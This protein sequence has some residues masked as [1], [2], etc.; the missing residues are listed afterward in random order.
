MTSW[1]KNGRFGRHKGFLLLFAAVAIFTILQLSYSYFTTVR[2]PS[3][4]VI[5]DTTD[6]RNGDL[7]FRNGYGAESRF[8][9][10]VSNGDYSHIAFAYRGE[11]GWKAVH[12]VPGESQ[13]IHD[14]DFLKCEPI[15]DFYQQNRAC[16]GAFA[17]VDCTDS[18]ALQALSFALDKVKRKFSFDHSYLLDDSNQY[19]CTELIYRAYL[20]AGINLAD[21]RRHEMPMPGT[22]GR[23]IFPSDILASPF[24]HKV[25]K[26]A[27]YQMGTTQ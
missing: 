16:S 13:N 25:R 21:E 15:E 2:Y 7:L 6:L 4:K 18:I 5:V 23:F 9:T 8:V 14:K 27:V 12:A 3:A 19:Y 24:I 20:Q 17:R 22:D 11:D 26:L 1:M 10:G